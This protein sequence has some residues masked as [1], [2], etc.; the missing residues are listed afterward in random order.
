MKKT[1]FTLSLSILTAL[2]MSAFAQSE[3]VTPR[4]SFNIAKEVKPPLWE[5]VEEPYFVDADGNH[6]VDANEECKIVMK[7]KNVGMGDGSGLTAKISAAGTRSGI[8]VSDKKLP[9]IKV[10]A[11]A[12]VEFPISAN[13]STADGS[14]DFTVYV[15]EPMGFSTDKYT[16]KVQSRAFQV[17]LIEVKDYVATCEDGGK[18]VKMKN[19]QLQV[20]IQNTRHGLGENQ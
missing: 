5:I 3:A 13:M 20:L 6:A 12:T 10:G 14:V 8:T 9:T 15:D 2:G 7:V 1:L 16:V 4:M 18:L 17:P 11:T 19:F